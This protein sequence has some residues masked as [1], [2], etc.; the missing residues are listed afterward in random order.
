MRQGND[1]GLLAKAII[2][3]AA[4][5]VIKL[6]ILQVLSP[7]YKLKSKDNVIKKIV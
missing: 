2:I 5:L 1:S 6:F 4:I 7:I 3:V